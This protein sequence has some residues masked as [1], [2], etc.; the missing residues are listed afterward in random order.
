MTWPLLWWAHLG[1]ALAVNWGRRGFPLLSLPWYMWCVCSTRSLFLMVKRCLVS[2][3]EKKDM[4]WWR[5]SKRSTQY[6]QTFAARLRTEQI[7]SRAQCIEIL[8]E[9][10]TSFLV[11][12]ISETKKS[13]IVFLVLQWQMGQSERFT[14]APNQT[15]K[16][17]THFTDVEIMK[18]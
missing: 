18:K 12:D 13:Q 11:Y 16:H 3:L 8:I 15:T 6:K 7:Q 9:L 17:W 1:W 5:A 14:M 2:F 10:K 4:S